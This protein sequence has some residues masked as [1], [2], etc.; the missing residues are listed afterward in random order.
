MTEESDSR[1]LTLDRVLD[2][3]RRDLALLDG[4]RT[5]EAL[6]LPAARRRRAR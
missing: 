3:P 2:A 6:V 5:S 1:V 4:A